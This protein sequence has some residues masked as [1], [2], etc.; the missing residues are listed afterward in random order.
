MSTRTVH[1][2]RD[3]AAQAQ[4]Q[5]ERAIQQADAAWQ[6]E[7]RRS[8]DAVHLTKI[9]GDARRLTERITALAE[10]CDR[11]NRDLGAED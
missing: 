3:A 8:F 1:A 5:L 7:A 10:A 9:H 11:V 6:D 2:Q 4:R